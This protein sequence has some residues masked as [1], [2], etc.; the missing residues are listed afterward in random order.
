MLEKKMGGEEDP[1][2]ATNIHITIFDKISLIGS[3]H[4]GVLLQMHNTS[5]L[6]LAC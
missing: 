2:S 4:Y 5:K 3:L 6:K 1:T